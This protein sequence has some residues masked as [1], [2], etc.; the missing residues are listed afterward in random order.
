MLSVTGINIHIITTT[1]CLVCVFYSSI[2]GIKAIIWTDVL[3]AIIMIGAIAFIVIKGTINVGGFGVIWE[4]NMA[5]GRLEWPEM[6]FDP[7]VRHSFLSLFIGGT[8]FWIELLAVNQ[9]LVQRYLTVKNVGASRRS[10]WIFIFGLIIVIGLC[11]FN[12]LL[13]FATYHDCD[14]LTT[15]V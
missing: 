3:Q 5:A 12:G 2:G 10:L 8:V 13:I 15:K 6:T 9:S 14:P 11:I 4:R 7:T 1:V